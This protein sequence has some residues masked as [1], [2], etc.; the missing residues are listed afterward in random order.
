MLG[1]TQRWWCDRRA[2]ALISSAMANEG[3]CVI[4]NFLPQESVGELLAAMIGLRDAGEVDRGNKPQPYFDRDINADPADMMNKDN[5]RRK[6]AA[7]DDNITFCGSSDP[8]GRMI[9]ELY[10]PEVDALLTRLRDGGEGAGCIPAVAERLRTITFREETMPAYYLESTRGRYQQHID[11]QGGAWRW[12]T[13]I[14]Y[15]NHNWQYSDGGINRL[16][17]P[18]AYSTEVKYEVLPI[19]NRLFLLWGNEECPHEI[20]SVFRDRYAIN[21]FFA[22]GPSMF[23]AKLQLR[24]Q[25]A[26]PDVNCL[27]EKAELPKGVM[28]FLHQFFPV[29]PLSVAEA[30]CRIGVE[31]GVA[32]NLSRLHGFI[33]EHRLEADEDAHVAMLHCVAKYGGVPNGSADMQVARGPRECGNCLM[34]TRQGRWGNGPFAGHWY[35]DLCWS[36]WN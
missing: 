4:D 1:G 11:S 25:A 32:E 22:D 35:C 15:L 21:T 30:L 26:V 34:L 19:A 13:A 20:T 5:I 16:Y 18:G 6:W 8:R 10:T 7:W 28:E 17:C 24:P 23:G 31:T 14:F 36:E 27:P 12:F 3:F 2:I 9:H 29:Q 33:S